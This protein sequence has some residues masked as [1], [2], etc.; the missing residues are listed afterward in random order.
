MIHPACMS[1]K[2]RI[3][4]VCKYFTHSKYHG[5]KTGLKYVIINFEALGKYSGA[6]HTLLNL[7]GCLGEILLANHE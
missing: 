6:V 4:A 2:A 7:K 3:F 5:V 1:I